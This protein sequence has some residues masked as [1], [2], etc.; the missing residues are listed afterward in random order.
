MVAAGFKD[1]TTLGVYPQFG[2]GENLPSLLQFTSLEDILRWSALDVSTSVVRDY[3][4]QKSLYPSTMAATK[5]DH[6]L[7]QAV[8][9]Q[10]LYLAMQ[11]AKRDF[12]R[13]A[14]PPRRGLLPHF[15]PILA[16]GGVLSEA[17]TAAQGLLLLLDA[18]QPVGI[19]TIILD[20]SNLLPVLGAASVCNSIL[21]VQ[22]L[23][24]GAFQSLGTTVSVVGGKVQGAVI[25]RA[26]LIYENGTEAKTDIKYGNL[27]ILPL[28]TGQSAKLSL[29]AQAGV[30]AGFG[31][32]KTGT[33]TVSGGEMGVVIDARGRPLVLPADAGLRRETIKK[34]QW[35][36]GEAK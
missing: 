2:L 31:P 9:R 36:L 22:V 7:A 8:T 6:S 29:Q 10:A 3:L 14:R 18:I 5:E 16:G 15:E 21:P 11:A 35:M 20:R 28:P 19:S 25:A 13:S 12:P 33:L 4:Y 17:P 23:E 24:S 1:K 30:D 34:W 27:E 26:R 32:G